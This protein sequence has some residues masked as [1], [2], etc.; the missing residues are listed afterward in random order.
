[1]S[2][3]MP[4][5]LAAL[6][7]FMTKPGPPPGDPY[8]QDAKALTEFCLL[9]GPQQA[10]AWAAGIY[11]GLARRTAS[12]LVAATEL[13]RQSRDVAIFGLRR[14]AALSLGIGARFSLPRGKKAPS[15]Q[16]MISNDEC[17]A[18]RVSFKMGFP[19]R[20]GSARVVEF[21]IF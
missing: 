13:S 8:V 11:S 3:P 2:R 10:A 16:H 4:S 12:L 9:F 15:P 5:S 20:A 14:L 18:W 19:V 7:W 6:I 17:L 21:L 1:M